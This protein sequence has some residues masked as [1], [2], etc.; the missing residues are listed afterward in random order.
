MIGASELGPISAVV[1]VRTVPPPSRL[2]DCPGR[3]QR[4]HADAL[5][6][7]RR[8]PIQPLML[9][10]PTAQASLPTVRPTMEDTGRIP[11]L[12]NPCS[13]VP[14]TILIPSVTIARVMR[15]RLL[16]T[17]AATQ[18]PRGPLR[19]SVPALHR[20]GLD[21]AATACAAQH[22]LPARFPFD[23]CQGG[24]A[25]RTTPGDIPVVRLWPAVP[26]A[27]SDSSGETLA[28]SAS[29]GFQFLGSGPDSDGEGPT[30]T[31]RGQQ[32]HQLRLARE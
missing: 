32:R 16:S 10:A 5:L 9:P 28:C 24:G 8:T 29:S 30:L 4:R 17:P 23:A 14:A 7:W 13:A 1:D 2:G 20:V 19:H 22:A 31:G 3:P 15:R 11:T 12:S 6:R 25:S 18:P 26:A 21:A 27:A